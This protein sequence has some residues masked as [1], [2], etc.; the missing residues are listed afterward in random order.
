MGQVVGEHCK[1]NDIPVN[2]VRTKKLTNIR[3][4][5]K[6]ATVVLKAPRRLNL[7][8][9]LE[10]VENDERV[11]ITPRGIRIRKQYL[12]ESERRKHARRLAVQDQ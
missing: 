2:V 3:S 10:Y 11:E 6:D 8:S 7:E 12:V 4:S 1:P 9:A 5:T